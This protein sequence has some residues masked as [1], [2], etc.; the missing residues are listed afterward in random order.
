MAQCLVPT[1]SRPM[2]QLY[3]R[4]PEDRKEHAISARHSMYIFPSPPS[5]PPSP[6]QRSGPST[7]SVCSS[8]GAP[9]TL[10]SDTFH[11]L[12]QWEWSEGSPIDD[13]GDQ[14]PTVIS[15]R[16]PQ[17][18]D[19]LALTLR[20]HPLQDYLSRPSPRHLHRISTN[21]PVSPISPR[22]FH[23][24]SSSSSSDILVRTPAHL[25]SPIPH[26][27][28]HIPFLSFIL[29]FL[30]I[31]DST[32]YLLTHTSPHS[33]LFPG[34][35]IMS[36]PRLMASER[37]GMAG[38]E[39]PRLLLEFDE[40]SSTYARLKEGHA[41]ACDYNSVLFSLGLSFEHFSNLWG[42]VRGFVKK[43]RKDPL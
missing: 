26:G 4:D 23:T 28:I 14:C 6:G 35:G 39:V 17:R 20:P 25:V 5:A 31:D 29:S 42:F 3:A 22:S 1:N 16:R 21:I 24:L 43:M 36:D 8:L 18:Q 19:P 40:E 41:V 10:S 32:V 37:Q 15:P 33:A 30:P 27:R 2:R 34:D 38:T 11:N 9:T 7:G 13:I 12:D